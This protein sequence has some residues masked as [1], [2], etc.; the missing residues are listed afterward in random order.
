MATQ[1]TTTAELDALPVGSG[2]TYLPP[3]SRAT[4]HP[5]FGQKTSEGDWVFTGSAERYRTADILEAGAVITV[6][7]SPGQTPDPSPTAL[8]LAQALAARDGEGGAFTSQTKSKAAAV[9]ANRYIREAQGIAVH[10][11]APTIDPTISAR[12]TK[13]LTDA[14]GW[15]PD[16]PEAVTLADNVARSAHLLTAG[17][18]ARAHDLLDALIDGP[19]ASASTG[20]PEPEDVTAEQVEAFRTAWTSADRAAF[21]EG[22]TLEPGDR[23]RAGLK[24]VRELQVA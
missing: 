20:K 17:T 5:R 8:A 6:L 3:R 15:L 11:P 23:I 22:R 18:R 24:A 9:I 2:I 10:L 12:V 13:R 14:W 1:T 19:T 21:T 16:E 7:P 4:Q